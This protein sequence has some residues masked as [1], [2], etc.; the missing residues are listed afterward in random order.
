MTRKAVV[1]P[2]IVLTGL[3]TQKQAEDLEVAYI[4]PSIAD[5]L[6]ITPGLMN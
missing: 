2:I 1:E 4:I 3:L 5:L 6:K